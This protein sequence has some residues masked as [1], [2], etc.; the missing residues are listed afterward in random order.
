MEFKFLERRTCFYPEEKAS[1]DDSLDF[2][3]EPLRQGI[4]S[5]FK[6]ANSS[7]DL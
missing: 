5:G 2:A 3:P 4:G 1:I 6:E 7:I